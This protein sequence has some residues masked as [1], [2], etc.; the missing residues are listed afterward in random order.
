VAHVSLESHHVQRH[1]SLSSGNSGQPYASRRPRRLRASVGLRGV[2]W[3]LHSIRAQWPAVFKTIED[4]RPEGV[5]LKPEH[6]RAVTCKPCS[7]RPRMSAGHLFTLGRRFKALR[8][9]PRPV[10]ICSLPNPNPA[11]LARSTAFLRAWW[12]KGQSEPATLHQDLGIRACRRWPE[13]ATRAWAAQRGHV[14]LQIRRSSKDV[15]D[16]AVRH[17]GEGGDARQ[18]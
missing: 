6:I 8:R 1:R 7:F 2:A 5:D 15:R 9:Q 3:T 12:T 16:E 4:R 10:S 11:K 17:Q 14:R 18:S 13:T